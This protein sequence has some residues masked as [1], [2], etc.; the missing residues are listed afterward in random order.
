ME[1]FELAPGLRL[2]REKDLLDL[3]SDGRAFFTVP[4]KLAQLG[5]LATRALSASNTPHLD[6]Q[7]CAGLLWMNPT[8]PPTDLRSNMSDQTRQLALD[9]RYAVLGGIEILISVLD[10]GYLF[11]S[12]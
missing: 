6:L 11:K 1:T 8:P 3:S 4:S 12:I 10:W 9:T 7:S 5:G 2:P